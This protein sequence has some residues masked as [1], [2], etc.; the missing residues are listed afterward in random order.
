[1]ETLSKIRILK[2]IFSFLAVVASYISWWSIAEAVQNAQASNI[3]APLFFISL[4]MVFLGV[5][6][7]IIRD[8]KN[9]TGLVVVV[10]LQSVWFAPN[11][12]HMGLLTIAVILTM[13]GVLK[14]QDELRERLQLHII[15]SL[16]RGFS[17]IILSFAL[18][19]GSVY[20]AQIKELPTES[21]IPKIE[22]GK[23]T[24]NLVYSFLGSINPQLSSL[25]QESITLDD[26]LNNI[27]Q[28]QI[29]QQAGTAKRDMVDEILQ[30]RGLQ[31]DQ[32]HEVEQFVDANMK[33][34]M[35]AEQDRTLE[36]GRKQF[37]ELAGVPLTGSEDIKSVFSLILNNKV[38]SFA[39]EQT[40]SEG[41]KLA[42]PLIITLIL[43]VAIMPIASLLKYVWFVFSAAFVRLFIRLHWLKVHKI[44]KLAE[45]LE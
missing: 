35:Q 7:V 8:K 17:P 5:C 21:L 19:F 12:W 23:R 10:L 38:Q 33:S 25:Q 3:L 15:Y 27:T 16:R 11:A 24:E 1:M 4:M 41:S 36:Q 22:L 9:L 28:G 29:E 42:L 39:L 18:I 13:G 2:G 37:S 45:V 43:F 6:F 34:A 40:L 14:I 31:E 20:F 30:R 32:R 44:S 26:F